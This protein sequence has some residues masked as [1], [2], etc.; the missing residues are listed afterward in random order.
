MAIQAGDLREPQRTALQA[1]VIATALRFGVVGVAGA[2]VNTISLHVLY[3]LA[4]L[5]LLLASP[6][7]VELAVVHNYLL[8]DRWTFPGRAP[9]L[10]RFARFN[11]SALLTLLVNVF[12]VWVLVGSGI[13]Y[14]AANL[15]GIGLG[16]ALNFG[17]SS[18]WVWRRERA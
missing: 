14:T 16:A 7:S 13:D 11:A 15:A 10:S 5:P 9:S 18:T 6:V 8:N 12:A 3:G 2:C 1:P 17:A 4:H